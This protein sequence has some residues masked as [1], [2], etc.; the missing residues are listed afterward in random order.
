MNPGPFL[1]AKLNHLAPV[2][3]SIVDQDHSGAAIVYNVVATVPMHAMGVTWETWRIR[4]QVDAYAST[5]AE[6]HTLASNIVQQLSR[7]RGTVEVGEDEVIHVKDCLFN[8]SQDITSDDGYRVSL[9]FTIII[10]E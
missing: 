10:T 5:Y 2:Y 6:V 9:D 4:V 3:P 8:D 7:F 1:V